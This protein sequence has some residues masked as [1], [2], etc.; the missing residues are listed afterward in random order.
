MRSPNMAVVAMGV[1]A[2]V[3]TAA[4]AVPTPAIPVAEATAAADLRLAAT[5]AAGRE[6]HTHAAVHTV[7]RAAVR[8]GPGR[9]KGAVVTQMLRPDGIHFP[10]PEQEPEHEPEQASVG[11]QAL[12][13]PWHR[14]EDQ[15]AGLGW[16]PLVRASPTGNGTPSVASAARPDRR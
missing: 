11:D 3:F 9:G 14:V 4:V 2:E 15:A 6:I 1:V 5:I 7:A 12:H 10:V 13:Q 16:A 8:R